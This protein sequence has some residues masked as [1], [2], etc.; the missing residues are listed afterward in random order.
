VHY[1]FDKKDEEIIM[2]ERILGFCDVLGKDY[3]TLSEGDL[4]RVKNFAKFLMFSA[5]ITVANF[6]LRKKNSD[7]DWSDADV[8]RAK[9]ANFGVWMLMIDF[10]SEAERLQPS[11][12][13]VGNVSVKAGPRISWESLL[14][15]SFYDPIT[16]DRRIAKYF[17]RPPDLPITLS[18]SDIFKMAGGD[19]RAIYA[20][21]FARLELDVFNF[22]GGVVVSEV[23]AA[24]CNVVLIFVQIWHLQDDKNRTPVE[25][26]LIGVNIAVTLLGTFVC[27]GSAIYMLSKATDGIL[28]DFVPEAASIGIFGI[29]LL[30]VGAVIEC[31]YEV[32]RA[33]D[34]TPQQKYV[35]DV[36]PFLNGVHKPPE[37]WLR[38]HELPGQ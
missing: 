7:Q 8:D 10:N 12:R 19:Y 32:L 18:W 5:S 9:F 2:T 31:V 14:E 28:I 29:V 35:E 22:S 13:E 33:N 6:V 20:N 4:N 15:D 25:N 26:I 17:M 24:V 38:A 36:A 34:P 16:Q 21:D 30:A 3:S 23:F 27:E 37:E 1:F 11:T